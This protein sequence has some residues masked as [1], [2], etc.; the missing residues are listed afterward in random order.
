MLF[1]GAITK[2]YIF[3]FVASC[4]SQ[5]NWKIGLFPK[6]VGKIAISSWPEIRAS[7]ASLCSA[8]RVSMFSGNVTNI[9]A[10]LQPSSACQWFRL[11]T[12]CYQRFMHHPI[13][14]LRCEANAYFIGSGCA[15]SLSF[16]F[17]GCHPRFSR[18]AALLL[19]ALSCA[20][21][22]EEKERRLAVYLLY[23]IL[24]FNILFVMII[25]LNINTKLQLSLVRKPAKFQGKQLTKNC[26]EL[27]YVW[28]NE[29]N[30][31][32]LT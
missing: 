24:V 25:I 8:F 6:P 18:L 10:V 1:C 22:T 16:L 12:F 11:L 2:M 20:W 7:N 14:F 21:L 30:Y 29:I 19:S 9:P 26:Y 23:V 17:L 31:H 3:G 5:N 15:G 27:S 4:I 28:S 32:W 13:V